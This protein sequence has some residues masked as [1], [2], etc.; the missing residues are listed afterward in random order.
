MS[1]AVLCR[2]W[3]DEQPDEDREAW[4][5]Q[6]ETPRCEACGGDV[7]PGTAHCWQHLDRDD[8]GQLDGGPRDD[9]DWRY[10]RMRDARDEAGR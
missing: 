4:V 10:D 8:I 1:D 9:G 5:I 7:V 6:N 2:D 3:C